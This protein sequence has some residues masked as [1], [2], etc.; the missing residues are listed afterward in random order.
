[1]K[2]MDVK[3]N[4]NSKA[5]QNKC[6]SVVEEDKNRICKICENA[7]KIAER[8]EEI[9]KNHAPR[10]GNDGSDSEKRI[11]NSGRSWLVTIPPP[12]SHPARKPDDNVLQRTKRT[13]CGTID[14]SKRER[15]QEHDQEAD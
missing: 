6:S 13:E 10:E 5:A 7:A 14:S 11:V 12:A 3:E 1:M 4:E 9:H 8:L 2:E 15:K